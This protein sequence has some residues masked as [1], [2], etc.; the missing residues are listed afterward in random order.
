MPRTNEQLIT[1]G[2]WQSTCAKRSFHAH[3]VSFYPVNYR[4]MENMQLA[5]GF[6]AGSDLLPAAR[7]FVVL[8]DPFTQANGFGGDLDQLVVGDEFDGLPRG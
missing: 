4:E 5:G 6:L 3:P 2:C 7:A 8:Q 1:I